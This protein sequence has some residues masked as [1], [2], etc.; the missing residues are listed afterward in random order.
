MKKGWWKLSGFGED[1]EGGRQKTKRGIIDKF[2]LDL[3]ILI[4][5]DT[6]DATERVGHVL[7][8]RP[9]I[10][11]EGK[12]SLPQHGWSG[13][14]RRLTGSPFPRDIEWTCNRG[15][16]MRTRYTDGNWKDIGYRTRDND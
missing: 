12:R 16:C 8:I 1:P 9:G 10:C 11:Y 3:C 14:W 15:K 5:R 13:P 4:D 6:V 7:D 2:P